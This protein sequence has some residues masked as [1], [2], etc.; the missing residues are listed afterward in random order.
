VGVF[1]DVITMT[2]D[3]LSFSYDDRAERVVGQVV[4]PNFFTAL[5]VAPIIGEGFA[6]E[7]R[8]GHWAPEVVLSYR[9]WKRRFA[10][11]PSVIGRTVRLNASPFTIVGVSAPAFYDVTR[12]FEP[13]LRLPRLPEGRQLS[14]IELLGDSRGYSLQT[15]ARLKPGVTI[16]QAEAAANIQFQEFLRTTT[17]PEISRAGYQRLRLAPG[18]KGW[19]GDLAG[20]KAPLFVLFALVAIVLVI[21]CANVA[22]LLL[23][24]ATA[25]R[26]ELAVRA[27]M[28]ANRARLIRQMLAESLLLSLLGGTLAVLVAS[29]VAPMLL[30]FLPQGHINIVL[31]LHPD[32]RVLL[33]TFALS[34]LTT[35]LFGLAPAIQATRGDLAATLKADTNAS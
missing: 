20:F 7:V 4:S 25:R 14:Q 3:G 27:S 26:R 30:S 29:W 35:F 11:D 34:F 28:G 12:G 8:A 6:P 33:F 19:S 13:E 2:S 15:M 23:A 17:S 18:D 22:N 1:S 24:R 32:T 5:G 16:A 21:A 10:G 31:D 9:F